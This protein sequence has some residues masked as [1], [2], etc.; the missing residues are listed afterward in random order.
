M[1]KLCITGASGFIGTSLIKCL[2][3]NFSLVLID[4]VPPKIQLNDKS[5]FIQMDVNNIETNHIEDCVGIIH[6]AAISRVIWG[7]ERPLETWTVNVETTQHLLN[8]AQQMKNKPWII[9]GSSREIYGEPNDLPVNEKN[10]WKPINRY[11]VSK[12]AA[13]GLI[14]LYGENNNV[15]TII[16]RFSNVYGN[17][18]DQMDRVIPKFMKLAIQDDMLELQGSTNSFDFTHINDTINGL[19]LSIKYINTNRISSFCFN[20]CTGVG[21]TLDELSKLILE[22]TKSSSSIKETTRRSYDVNNYIGD[23]SLANEILQYEPKVELREGL[24]ILYNLLVNEIQ[25]VK[26]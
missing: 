1:N 15:S 21:T 19:L 22:I 10:S 13:E 8:I 12:L 26:L 16:L 3:A 6:L 7:E 14:K 4:I 5:K 9:Y 25:E 20:I 24:I 11:G 2:E 17:N 18:F 23:F